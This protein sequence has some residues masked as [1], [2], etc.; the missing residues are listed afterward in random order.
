MKEDK[1]ISKSEYSYPQVNGFIAV[2]QYMFYR[3]QG[4]KCLMVRFANETEYTMESLV[5][6]LIQVDSKGG[7]LSEKEYSCDDL[8]F[9][10]RDIYAMEK[11]IVVEDRCVDIRIQV[12]CA[13]SGKYQYTVNDEG[14]LLVHY[15]AEE[16]WSYRRHVPSKVRHGI[17]LSAKPK[18]AHS[19][20]W[21]SFI[22]AIAIILILLVNAWPYIKGFLPG[23]SP[24]ADAFDT[25]D[26]TA[27]ALIDE[28]YVSGVDYVEI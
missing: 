9:E 26:V 12:V 5:F 7:I 20:G 3:Y 22:T 15:D 28:K 13:I 27:V 23:M 8:K 2:K 14:N 4:K 18:K 24:Q 17:G 19:N 25:K 6:N 11:G 16:D 1:L 21:L 10:P